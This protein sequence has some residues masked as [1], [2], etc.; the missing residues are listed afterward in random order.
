MGKSKRYSEQLK[1]TMVDIMSTYDDY[2]ELKE[3]MKLGC[4]D[5][6]EV[7][8]L[9]GNKWFDKV[10]DFYKYKIKKD[11]RNLDSDSISSIC[12]I[13][14]PDNKV[15]G[16]GKKSEKTKTNYAIKPENVYGRAKI[17]KNNKIYF[18]RG[19]LIADSIIEFT[20]GFNYEKWENFVMITDWC[21]RANTDRKADRS[22]GMWHFEEIVL[23]SLKKKSEEE[24]H[25]HYRVTPVFKKLDN[26]NEEES[27]F[28]L[29][30][31]GIIMEVK[32][33]SERSS[34]SKEIEKIEF[35]VFIPNAQRNLVINYETADVS[36]PPY[37]SRQCFYFSP[38]PPMFGGRGFG[39]AWD[40][41]F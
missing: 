20:S 38:Y 18:N 37:P 22:F 32:T 3:Y 7:L 19:H 36:S 28:E 13:L 12:V 40:G 25:L 17:K 29:L 34:S 8:H 16:N 1:P 5:E 27:D 11:P 6:L 15:Q 35:N 4:Y 2:P 31:R 33:C 21:N 41:L 39:S 9:N 10:P 26:D 30:P 23:N 14:S 24:F